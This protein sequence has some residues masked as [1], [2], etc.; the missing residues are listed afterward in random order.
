MTKPN[1]ETCPYCK[2]TKLVGHKC[3]WCKP[4]DRPQPVRK[5]SDCGERL[6]PLESNCI[7]TA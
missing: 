3:N 2:G 1:R 6:E 5:I 7:K 4:V